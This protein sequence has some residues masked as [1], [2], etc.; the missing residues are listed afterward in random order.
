MGGLLTGGDERWAA[1]HLSR[2]SLLAAV[3]VEPAL[4]LVMA[5]ALAPALALALPVTRAA[6]VPMPCLYQPAG[7]GWSLSRA[8]SG[9]QAEQEGPLPDRL[10]RQRGGQ[11][12]RLTVTV[13]SSHPAFPAFQ[14]STASPVSM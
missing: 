11:A 14:V 13:A 12:R 6:P 10:T 7:R 4:A 5:P 8:S 2:M 9:V 1:G 3:V